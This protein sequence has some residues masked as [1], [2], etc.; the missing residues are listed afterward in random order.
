[1]NDYQRRRPHSSYK[2]RRVGLGQEMHGLSKTPEYR[3][4]KYMISRCYRETD[5]DFH[6][7]GGRGVKIS[8]EWLASFKTFYEDMGPRP[9]KKHSIDRVDPYGNYSKENCRWVTQD[10]QL[11]NRRKR[12]ES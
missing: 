6:Y 12:N 10:V 3:I 5:K 7:Y 8:D 11:K 1:M 9:S 4:F 2:H